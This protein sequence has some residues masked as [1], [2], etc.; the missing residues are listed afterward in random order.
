[1]ESVGGEIRASDGEI[2]AATRW[3]A[4]WGASDASSHFGSEPSMRGSFPRTNAGGDSLLV[5]SSFTGVGRLFT[6]SSSEETRAQRK[7]AG[8]TIRS[9]VTVR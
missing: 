9:A 3:E 2:D 1:M 5:H 8:D 6:E 7:L 4:T